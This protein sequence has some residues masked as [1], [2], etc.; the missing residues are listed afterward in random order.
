MQ[1]NRKINN[2]IVKLETNVKSENGEVQTYE[3]GKNTLIT[4]PNES[5]KSAIVESISLALRG[6]APNILLK[7]GEVKA[8]K[9]LNT[10]MPHCTN[11]LVAKVMRND[12]TFAEWSMARGQRGSNIA[13][14]DFE[15]T[16]MPLS[17]LRSALG[18]SVESAVRY[19][20]PFMGGAVRFKAL[21]ENMD[22][23]HIPYHAMLEN[24]WKNQWASEDEQEVSSPESI[25]D[26][27]TQLGKEKR[28]H[29]AIAKQA[30]SALF[31]FSGAKTEGR[32]LNAKWREL[33][34]A[35]WAEKLVKLYRAHPDQREFLGSQL[36]AQ[37]VTAAKGLTRSVAVSEELNALIAAG[38][39][40]RLAKEFTRRHDAAMEEVKHC[41]KLSEALVTA[42]TNTISVFIHGQFARL[43]SRF[44]PEGE[45][46][47]FE[48]TRKLEVHLRR[49]QNLYRALSGSTEVRVLAAIGAALGA[50]V[51]DRATILL[52]DDRMWD[53]KTLAR[54]MR[55]LEQAPCQVIIMS[56]D[57]PAGR[58]RKAW[59]RV[60]LT[61][62]AP[63]ES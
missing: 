1:Y 40:G 50:C 23:A 34:D 11:N 51:E 4:G 2:P 60:Q 19:L 48:F 18:G 26:F 13:S 15:S 14:M 55:A 10:L 39:K 36:K 30:E 49:G 27:L 47:E 8:P 41:K 61:G 24:R 3:L 43:V 44:L 7:A 21:L 32:E 33:F 6:S 38:E 57:E 54:T 63:Q 22:A 52:L 31:M 59:T 20:L 5:G 37:G 25:C 35:L 45:S 42:V 62:P 28:E 46:V 12:G 9:E 16:L 56:T 29:A 53:R 58:Q 17:D